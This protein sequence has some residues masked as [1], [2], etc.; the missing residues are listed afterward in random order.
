MRLSYL[1]DG[2][3]NSMRLGIIVY[4]SVAAFCRTQHGSKSIGRINI[5]NCLVNVYCNFQG[6]CIAKLQQTLCSKYL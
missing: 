1:P 6:C 5:N 4:L 2:I 3:K